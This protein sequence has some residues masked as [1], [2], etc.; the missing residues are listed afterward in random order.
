MIGFVFTI[1]AHPILANIQ[2][3]GATLGIF[4]VLGVMS[5]FSLWF[6]WLV[7]FSER[8]AGPVRL[9]LD[10]LLLPT[11]TVS[12]IAFA[13]KWIMRIPEGTGP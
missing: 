9:F 1:R 5:F 3:V 6:G 10:G 11:A 13:M 4:G 8:K 12:I 2:G 7:A